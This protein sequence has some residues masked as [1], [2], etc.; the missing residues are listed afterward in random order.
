MA[1]T[2]DKNRS[3]KELRKYL[4]IN[5]REVEGEDRLRRLEDDEG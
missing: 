2:H 5:E 4:R 3:G 1:G